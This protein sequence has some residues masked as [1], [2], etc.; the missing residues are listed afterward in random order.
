M[1]LADYAKLLF[2]LSFS[3][4]APPLPPST[5]H[6]HV[7]LIDSHGRK[8]II[9]GPALSLRGFSSGF[10]QKFHLISAPVMFSGRAGVRRLGLA[11]AA[12]YLHA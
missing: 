7:F 12:A 11:A 4:A 8:K 9:F 6:R 3:P 2:F 1:A 10:K 5:L